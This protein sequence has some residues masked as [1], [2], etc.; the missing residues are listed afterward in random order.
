MAIK[1][2]QSMRRKVIDEKNQQKKS[3]TPLENI[4]SAQSDISSGISAVNDTIT[5][6]R[7]AQDV[8]QLNQEIQSEQ[9][10]GIQNGIQD[11]SAAEEL[12]LEQRDVQTDV[13]KQILD[14]QKKAEENY[15]YQP[16]EQDTQE[17][18]FAPIQTP[19]L[20][21]PVTPP[22]IIQMPEFEKPEPEKV[23]PQNED[24][25][26]K[27]QSTLLQGL[28][29]QLKKMNSG[30]VGIASSVSRILFQMTLDAVKMM[31]LLTAGVLAFDA[32]AVVAQVIWAKYGDQITAA[33]EW[34]KSAFG[35]VVEGIKS[36][37]EAIWNN[38]IFQ[39]MI[40]NIALMFRD[41]K[42]GT[43]V[44]GI[45]RQTK[46]GFELISFMLKDAFAAIM[47]S[48]PGLKG[49]AE[50]MKLNTSEDKLRSGF[51]LSQSEKD[52][53]AKRRS[54]GGID[55][56]VET[57]LKIRME[58]NPDEGLESSFWT[59]NFIENEAYK[60]AYAEEKAKAEALS[61]SSPEWQM[62]IMDIEAAQGK[63]ERSVDYV[64][65][66]TRS[67]GTQKMIENNI[68]NLKRQKAELSDAPES[69][70][71]YFSSSLDE[72]IQKAEQKL[73][74]IKDNQKKYDEEDRNRT[75]TGAINPMNASKPDNV[76]VPAVTPQQE[77]SRPEQQAV[78]VNTAV[79]N[80]Q[81][82]QNNFIPSR[83]NN[84]TVEI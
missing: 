65:S 76:M 27:G 12:A 70:K 61:N 2:M 20:K 56:Q 42:E 69:V 67:A 52:R 36:G 4:A 19:V 55:K 45:I 58:N 39:T 80:H 59:G 78:N 71:K 1:N 73:S 15:R 46:E 54:E 43:W 16:Q 14:A 82:T 62:R 81:T 64:D 10:Q 53:L 24:S 29:E 74:I 40:E 79:S 9:L 3:T 33:F 66:N 68:E 30:I 25:K 38:S 60:K 47:G 32:F 21:P 26:D 23:L 8:H 50:E 63:L 84:L 5:S 49:A 11:I 6:V 17:D 22:T 7:Q 57:R 44:E 37:I 13:L 72:S 28:S 34:L 75:I 18:F 83:Y 48:I 35:N 51:A 31:A 41:F 77:K